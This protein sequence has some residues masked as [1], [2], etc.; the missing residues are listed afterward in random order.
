MSD[1]NDKFLF[2]AYGLVWIVFM[3]YGWS[4]WR[5][6]ARLRKDLEEMK[7]KQPDL[8]ADK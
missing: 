8:A 7:V 2:L 3:L 1:P 6:Q 5:R 4:L